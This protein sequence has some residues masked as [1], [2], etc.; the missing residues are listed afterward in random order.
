ML[1]DTAATVLTCMYNWCILIGPNP[2]AATEKN[3]GYLR[4]RHAEYITYAVVKGK[5]TNVHHMIFQVIPVITTSA[6]SLLQVL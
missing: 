3:T 5:K 1:P 6:L 2:F 4:Y